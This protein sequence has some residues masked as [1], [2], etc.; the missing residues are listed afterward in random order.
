LSDDENRESIQ[1]NE[2]RRVHCSA[3]SEHHV[4]DRR[5]RLG[6][7]V[8]DCDTSVTDTTLRTF[9]LRIGCKKG[10]EFGAGGASSGSFDSV[11]RKERARLSSATGPRLGW[12]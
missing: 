8:S 7:N 10:E 11:W 6:S 2:N 9:R 4:C 5:A 12:C 1:K 3:F